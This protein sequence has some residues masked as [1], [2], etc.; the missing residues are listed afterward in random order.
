MV[1]RTL[2]Q[3]CLAL[4]FPEHCCCCGKIV[5]CGELV[6]SDCQS[7]LV[8]VLPPL[9]PY[10]GCQKKDCRCDNHARHAERCVSPYYYTGA[11]KSGILRLKF[12]NKPYAAE[13]FIQS[14]AQ[15][16][17]REYTGIRFDMIIPVPLSPATR[18][19]RSYNQSALLAAGLSEH[20]GIPW[21]EALVKL[22]N[23]AP[24]RSLPA[25]RR[26]G[27]VL[28]VFDINGDVILT[29]KTILLVD[30]VS[31]TG[32]TMHECAKMMKLY[33]AKAVY[34]VAATVTRLSDSE[35]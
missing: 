2:W 23:T 19:M 22:W 32:A 17:R 33:G 8:G 1:R 5:S 25:F 9:C 11:A 28:G 15:V 29:D 31:T 13:F 10:C 3:H 34:A 16:V 35:K 7:R 4:F 27:N 24:Q 30:D 26:S 20:L 12:Q 14:M 6:C 18:K 21:E